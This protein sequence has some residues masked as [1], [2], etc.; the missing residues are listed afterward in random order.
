VQKKECLY[1]WRCEEWQ[2][3]TCTSCN[4]REPIVRRG[5]PA[6]SGKYI[7]LKC[8]HPPCASGCGKK[9]PQQKD[10]YNVG[11]VPLW[12]CASCRKKTKY[13]RCTSEVRKLTCQRCSTDKNV[14]QYDTEDT[15]QHNGEIRDL[16]GM[17]LWTCD[18]C[19]RKDSFP[20][21][22]SGC[23][24]NRPRSAKSYHIKFRPF[25]TCATCRKASFPPC[26]SGCGRDRPTTERFRIQNMSIWT[27]TACRMKDLYPP[28]AGGCGVSRPAHEK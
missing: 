10:R 16:Q 14:R 21:C 22:A 8:T 27:C 19:V 17:P 9:R 5:P 18:V 26:A 15:T 13:M 11:G 25:W 4:V 24:R 6:I 3:P 2:S 20:P 7:C 1:K 28:C 23:G 12:S